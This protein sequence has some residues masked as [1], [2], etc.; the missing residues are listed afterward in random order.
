MSKK[1][2]DLVKKA[3]EIVLPYDR[4]SADRYLIAAKK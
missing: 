4:A 1:N 3:E 2:D